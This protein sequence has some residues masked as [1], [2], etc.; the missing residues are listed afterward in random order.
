VVED[1][2]GLKLKKGGPKSEEKK[3]KGKKNIPKE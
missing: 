2:V 3:A 1:L